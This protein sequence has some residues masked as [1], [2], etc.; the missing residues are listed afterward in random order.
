MI[1]KKLPYYDWF[2]VTPVSVYL[3]AQDE[4]GEMVVSKSWVGKCNYSERDG[5]TQT[6]DGQ[7]V[8]L[9]GVIH[10]KGDIFPSDP[11]I[12][13]GYVIIKGQ[14]IEISSVDRPRN[15]DGSVNHTRINLK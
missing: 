2:D 14:K 7:W 4:D 10:I 6:T 1:A 5:L 12:S 9:S 15:P 11:V 8:H 3:T 13:K